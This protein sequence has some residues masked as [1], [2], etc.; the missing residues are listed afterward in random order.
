MRGPGRDRDAAAAPG[1]HDGARVEEAAALGQRRVGGD[2]GDALLDRLGLAGQ[3]RLLRAQRRGVEQPHIR[4]HAIALRH[5]QQV[6]RHHLLG[7]DLDPGAVAAHARG[8]GDQL[9]QRRD[10]APRAVL[11]RETD[12]RVER[13]HGE[14]HRAVLDLPE[15]ERQCA[16]ADQRPHQRRAHLIEQQAGG[17]GLVASGSRLGPYRDSRACASSEV[18]PSRGA[19][20]AAMTSASG[21]ACH[22]AGWAR[23]H[24]AHAMCAQAPLHPSAT[25]ARL[26][27]CPQ[28]C[29]GMR[30]MAPRAGRRSVDAA[31]PLT[32]LGGS[33]VATI[34]VGVEDSPRSQDAVALAGDLARITGAEILAVC[35]FPYDDHPASHFNPVMRAPLYDAAWAILERLTEPLSDLPSVR[36]L[37]LA[38]PAPARALLDAAARSRGAADRRRLKPRRLSRPPA[39][40]QHGR[41]PAQWR[42]RRGRSSHRRDTGCDPSCRH[43]RI[44]A[45]FDGSPGAHAALRTAALIAQRLRNGLARDPRLPARMGRTAANCTFRPGFVRMTGAA[46]HAAREELQR[47]VAPISGAE[48]AFV[49]GDAA[50]ELTNESEVSHLMVIGSRGYGPAPAVLLGEVSAPLLRTAACPVIVVPNGVASPLDALFEQ[51][52]GKL[53]TVSAA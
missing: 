48:A 49:I 18:R 37:A 22:G 28:D 41:A 10:R 3:R 7:R 44:A 53:R 23:A 21:A 47:A 51:G 35:A 39:P 19:S 12:Q 40:G 26:R 6:A 16:G 38:D 36:R 42:S 4:G 24:R 11:L 13:H 32:R 17:R 1:G 9:R 46:E 5:L 43:E 14:H 20:S 50:R 2:G 34:I 15:R 33:T 27:S 45:A 30:P 52:S 8:L 25:P 31:P 29:P